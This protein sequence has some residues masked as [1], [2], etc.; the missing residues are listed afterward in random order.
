MEHDTANAAQG[1][2]ACLRRAARLHSIAGA[3]RRGLLSR[4]YASERGLKVGGISGIA[5]AAV[6]A[7][8]AKL[9]QFILNLG[10]GNGV[11]V[12]ELIAAFEKVSGQK[13]NYNLG[14][15]RPGDAR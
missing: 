12:L 2:R 8:I 10:T 3:I 1:F 6:V 5:A 9:N 14:P 4:S 7:R 13:L 11:T 15:R